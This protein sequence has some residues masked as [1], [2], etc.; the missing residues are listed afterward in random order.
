MESERGKKAVFAEVYAQN[1]GLVYKTVTYYVKDHYAAEEIVQSAFMKL[2]E[3]M[4]HINMD[5]VK[6]WLV[7]TARNMALNYNRDSRYEFS[8]EDCPEEQPEFMIDSMEDH[9]LDKLKSEQYH[10]LA[11]TIFG[12]LFCRN[13][14]WY[15]ALTITCVLEKPQEEVAEIMGI[16]LDALRSKLYRARNWIKENYREEFHQIE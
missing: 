14:S 7:T 2:Y 16:S 13:E 15:Y 12:A 5:A 3:H 8:V 1:V 9:M 6:T 11:E 10:E 4:D